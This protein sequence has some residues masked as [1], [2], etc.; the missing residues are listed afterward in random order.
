[1]RRDQEVRVLG[2][3]VRTGPRADERR[4]GQGRKAERQVL[5]RF[6]LLLVGGDALAGIRV[7]RGA[8][9][10]GARLEAAAVEVADAVDA[11]VEVDPAGNRR[12]LPTRGR[13]EEVDV[14]SRHAEVDEP[15]EE[16]CE[17]RAA[18]PDD[19]VRLEPLA[20]DEHRVAVRLGR[21]RDEV[22]AALDREL[23][24]DP[25][26]ISGPEHSGLGLEQDR[27][28]PLSIE[29]REEARALVGC[30]QLDGDPLLEQDAFALLAPPVRAG[31]E[32]R[33]TRR[34]DELGSRLALEVAPEV[35]RAAGRA[36]V[37]GVVA[38]R[39]AD[40]PRLP[41]RRRADV[42]RRVLLDE[43]DVPAA[44]YEPERERAA[45][46][47]GADD[48]GATQAGSRSRSRC[49][50]ATQRARRC[51][52]AGSARAAQPRARPAPGRPATASAASSGA[53]GRPR[54]RSP[55]PPGTRPP[56]RPRA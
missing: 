27:L 5:A 7:E 53:S 24:R 38:V 31:E 19:A 37:P 32:P 9:T 18:G 30:E 48:E 36:R 43:R 41:A 13:A 45:E 42:A 6:S 55:R 17:P 16:A 10:V 47:P 2:Q 56:A 46:D 26:R 14:L 54:A 25:R 35:E 28:E 3:G 4:P 49:R 20:A 40:Q 21:P 23:G 33:D 1:M 29:A 50:A 15:G 39:E 12:R 44:G 34:D 8:F 51:R 11:V 52:C 22:G